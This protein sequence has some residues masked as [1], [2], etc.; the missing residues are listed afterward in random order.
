MTCDDSEYS[1]AECGYEDSDCMDV[2][3]TKCNVDDGELVGDCVCDNFGEC[4]T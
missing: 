4:N 3:Y 2:I 1:T